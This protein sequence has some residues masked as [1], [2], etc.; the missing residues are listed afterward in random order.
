MN[1]Q[2]KVDSDPERPTKKKPTQ[3][4]IK[5]LPMMWKILMAQIREKNLPVIRKDAAKEP[6]KHKNYYIVIS[7]SSRTTKRVKK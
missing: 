7:T 1:N 5:C 4:P 6:E 2:R 3:N